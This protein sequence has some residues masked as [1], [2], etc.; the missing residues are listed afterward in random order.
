MDNKGEPLLGTH[1]SLC[2][3]YTEACRMRLARFLR[4]TGYDNG[5]RVNVTYG[6]LITTFNLFNSGCTLAIPLQ[7]SMTPL[8][9][10]V[11]FSELPFRSSP[12]F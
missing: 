2:K 4:D 9:C 6:D 7:C 3:L 12:A 5:T 11:S 8:H 1:R 10:G